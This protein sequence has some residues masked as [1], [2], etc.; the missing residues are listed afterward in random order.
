MVF[1]LG[2]SGQKI[3]IALPLDFPDTFTATGEAE[4]PERWWAAFN[5]QQLN[6]IID[7]ALR[8]N[9][10]IES[11]WQRLLVARAIFNREKSSFFP[12]LEAFFQSEFEE[13]TSGSD[14]QENFRLGL[15]SN[16]EIDL[17]GRIGSSVKAERFRADASL[18]DYHTAAI[19]LSAEIVSTWYG[20]AEAL[21]QVELINEQI[22]INNQVL[23]LMLTRFHSGQIRGVDVIRQKQLLESTREEKLNAEARLQIQKNQ[24]Y[25]LRGKLPAGDIDFMI[26]DLPELP[27]LPETGIP[28]ELIQRRPDIQNAFNLL[29]AADRELASAISSRYP[30]LSLTASVTSPAENFDDLLDNW[31]IA[32][33]GN[34]LGPVFYGGRLNAEVNRTR[35]FSKQLFFEY[36]QTV[37]IAFREVEDA[38]L[39]EKK[40]NEIIQS[41]NEQLNLATNVNEQLQIEYLNGAVNYLE[42]LTALVQEQQLRRDLLTARLAL[43]EFRI[44]LYRALAGDFETERES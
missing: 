41:L 13:Q 25:V 11:A 40:Q 20:L 27:P 8:S 33:A 31:A 15:S 10:T 6:T 24:L 2:C 42:V 29:L 3:D 43:I 14:V 12:G 28:S 44:S 26:S 22:D 7:S 37:L 39:Q 1:I 5:D 30:R 17:W 16:Y 34:L 35:A 23:E 32:I 21:S 18:N 36:A 38:L 9:F 4:I 19:T